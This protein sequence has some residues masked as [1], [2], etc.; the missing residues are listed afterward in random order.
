MGYMG[1]GLQRWIYTQKPRQFLSKSS[2]SI[3]S[4]IQSYEAPELHVYSGTA[5]HHQERYEERMREIRRAH[6]LRA[7]V[8]IV[9]LLLVGFVIWS[10]V[11]MF[12]VE[13]RQYLEDLP[14]R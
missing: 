8:A 12:T 3:H 14:G 13:H 6:P 5:A 1:F 10:L 2:K 4:S 7:L 11:Q 9:I